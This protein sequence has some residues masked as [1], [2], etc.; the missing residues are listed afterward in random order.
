MYHR[1]G[2]EIAVAYFYLDP[3]IFAAFSMAQFCLV[4]LNR[5]ESVHLRVPMEPFSEVPVKFK[6][7][8]LGR[9]LELD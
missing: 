6:R 5:V 8:N 4:Q 1:S 9:L 7:Q 2:I 3:V